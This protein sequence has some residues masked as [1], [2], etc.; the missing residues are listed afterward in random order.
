MSFLDK[1]FTK[2]PQQTSNNQAGFNFLDDCDQDSQKWF[3]C[4]NNYDEQNYS[5][6]VKK[7]VLDYLGEFGLEKNSK[8]FTLLPELKETIANYFKRCN[9]K[10]DSTNV[11]VRDGIF[12]LLQDLYEII[13]FNKNE[14]I[15]FT[16]PISGYFIQQ[17]YDKE[18]D[19][20]FLNTDIKN[21]WKVDFDE[22]EAILQKHKIKVLF[23]NY[24]NGTTGAVLT[25]EEVLSLAN[26]IKNNKDLLVIADESLRDITI[27]ENSQPFSLASVDN[28]ASQIITISSLKAYGLHNLDVAF[29]CCK[30]KPIVA[31]LFSETVNISHAN[32]H[33]AIAALLESDDNQRHLSEIIE[34]CQQNSNLVEEEIQAINENLGKKFGKNIDFIKPLLDD[35]KAG[36]S[37]LIQFSGLKGSKPETGNKTLETDLDIAEFLKRKTNIMMMPG[38]CCLLPEEEMILRLYLLKSKQELR[39]GFKKINE[40]VMQLR[41]L[42]QKITVSS[43]ANLGSGKGNIR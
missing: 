10:C 43:S 18:I 32:Q 9:I 26:I 40:A 11:I 42:S 16:L 41:M 23:L 21:G 5:A 4:D 2:K 15:L 6:T 38:Q 39:A 24:P 19:V 36:H 12:E 13:D 29:A 3:S 20:E 37:V 34:Q 22:L 7:S 17:C 31:G 14:K 33:I 30:S 35:V 28:I 25:K 1:L 27:D 8:N